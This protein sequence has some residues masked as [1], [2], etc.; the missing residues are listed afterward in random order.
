MLIL[1]INPVNELKTIDFLAIFGI[2]TYRLTHNGE[3][4]AKK[5]PAKGG[6]KDLQAKFEKETG[7]KAIH[8]GK[9]T[10]GFKDWKA[11]Q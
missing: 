8:C 7:K 3:K 10:K 6:E 2:I 1:D 11:A 5:A 9:L 4:M